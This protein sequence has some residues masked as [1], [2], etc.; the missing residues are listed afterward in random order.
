MSADTGVVLAVVG[1]L[2]AILAAALSVFVTRW[3]HRD[4]LGRVSRLERWHDRVD[5]PHDGLPS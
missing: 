3:E 5:D 1:S 2:F 4:L